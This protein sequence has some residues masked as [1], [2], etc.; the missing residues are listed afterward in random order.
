MYLFGKG[1]KARIVPLISQTIKILEKYIKIYN[2]PI[3]S[4]NLLF[5]IAKKELLLEWV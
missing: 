2:I 1:R 3:N 5:I 4:D